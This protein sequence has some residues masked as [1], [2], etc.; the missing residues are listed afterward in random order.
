MMNKENR[1][2][3]LFNYRNQE[4][5]LEASELKTY[6]IN[7]KIFGIIKERNDRYVLK[8]KEGD[9]FQLIE[10]LQ[11]KNK[12]T[13]ST[14]LKAEKFADLYLKE[15]KAS[16]VFFSSDGDLEEDKYVIKKDVAPSVSNPVM[17]PVG[18]DDLEDDLTDV[19]G[20]KS[21]EEDQD[22]DVDKEND[23]KEF[24]SK[25]GGKTGYM[26]DQ[27]E[28][29]DDE[30]YSKIIKSLM[31]SIS[32]RVDWNR[33]SEK[34]MNDIKKKM[35]PTNDDGGEDDVQESLNES[36]NKQVLN[37]TDV[38]V[39]YTDDNAAD[40][41]TVVY[42]IMQTRFK[43]ETVKVKKQIITN[44]DNL[45]AQ[46][47]NDLIV[48]Y[49]GENPIEHPSLHDLSISEYAN[50]LAEYL[51]EKIYKFDKYQSLMFTDDINDYEILFSGDSA[52]LQVTTNS[53]AKINSDPEKFIQQHYEKYKLEPF[54]VK[55]VKGLSNLQEN[56]NNYSVY[57]KNKETDP[58]YETYCDGA[59]VHY[60]I[61]KV[62]ENYSIIYKEVI[63]ETI[64]DSRN[65]DDILKK[66]K[67][68]TSIDI[69]KYSDDGDE[70]LPTKDIIEKL[71]TFNEVKGK[72][73]GNTYIVSIKST[74]EE[75]G[76]VLWEH[77]YNITYN[78]DYDSL[79]FKHIIPSVIRV[80]SGNEEKIIEIDSNKNCADYFRQIYYKKFL[81]DELTE[82]SK[83]RKKKGYAWPSFYFSDKK[84]ED[85]FGGEVDA[86]GGVEGAAD[87][88]DFGGIGESE[89]TDD[90]LLFDGELNEESDVQNEQG[91]YT[92]IPDGGYVEFKRLKSG[93]DW[94]KVGNDEFLPV[95]AKYPNGKIDIGYL[96]RG[97]LV[98]HWKVFQN[99]L[100]KA[101]ATIPKKNIHENYYE[102][103]DYDNI[104]IGEYSKFINGFFEDNNYEYFSDLNEEDRQW[105]EWNIKEIADKYGL[106][107]ND[108]AKMSGYS[109][110]KFPQPKS[111]LDMYYY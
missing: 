40:N 45:N 97:D 47:L 1:I 75:S 38:K 111:A 86:T 62:G 81:D 13:R 6:D 74:T 64:G 87:F 80:P 107:Y 32:A 37:K 14:L 8:V 15:L 102:D 76:N 67:Y 21:D 68:N 94:V 104:A 7:G 19:E 26:I 57:R 43:D 99:Y 100:G 96:T 78:E 49:L 60:Y 46:G 9:E 110:G 59:D 30:E 2:E 73:R 88:G 35:N 17:E 83:E 89:E 91:Y 50:V 31:N 55:N 53:I 66:L 18:D 71:Y 70:I 72:K 44:Y 42:S 10:G 34:D 5:K 101:K 69:D 61:N 84:Y 29:D 22:F 90:D 82:N 93:E 105:V 79:T 24:L 25:V 48:K 36:L 92:D 63:Y 108:L 27:L 16:K 3:Q 28:V 39:S 20:L 103:Y 11:N 12:F 4:Q 106:S 52:L 65:I 77:R 54:T 109:E 98:I 56:K 58:Y 41:A 23:P 95:W 33:I 51:D 85:L